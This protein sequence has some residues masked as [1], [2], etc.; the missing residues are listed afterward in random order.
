MPTIYYA[1]IKASPY[2]LAVILATSCV[3]ILLWL[4]VDNG[5]YDIFSWIHNRKNIRRN[6]ALIKKRVQPSSIRIRIQKIFGK[7]RYGDKKVLWKYKLKDCDGVEQ[8]LLDLAK[9]ATE[10]TDA[11]ADIYSV[12][13]VIEA[14]GTVNSKC[15][16]R[17]PDR[18]LLQYL[19]NREV[20]KE[21]KSVKCRKLHFP[22]E[23]KYYDIYLDLF[24]DRDLDLIEK[25][26]RNNY[27]L[28]NAMRDIKKAEMYGVIVLCKEKDAST[29]IEEYT[30]RVM[31]GTEEGLAE[32]EVEIHKD[33]NKKNPDELPIAAKEK[34]PILFKMVSN[35]NECLAAGGEIPGIS[36]NK[37]EL[38][39]TEIL[40]LL[41]RELDPGQQERIGSILEKVKQT[42]V[43]SENDKESLDT[44]VTI[45]A[46]Q[47][48]VAL[49]VPANRNMIA[50]EERQAQG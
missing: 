30:S 33:L 32:L 22:D 39:R 16:I 12:I 2:I 17:L 24:S 42:M 34:Y 4:T 35:I 25:N 38:Y 43:Q 37:W 28:K 26:I 31:R 50:T 18:F 5:M 20:W 41:E 36:I 10:C 44:E 29:L 40:A 49:D 48:A 8:I 1:L 23:T 13:D 46:I 15:V 9:S 19:N 7:A 21:G 3:L 47:N 27:S 45:E 6:K 11:S 14:D